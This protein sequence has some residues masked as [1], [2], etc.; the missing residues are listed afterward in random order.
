MGSTGTK[1]AVV[2]GASVE[3]FKLNYATN[4]NLDTIT[5]STSGVSATI[6]S[7]T[8]GDVEISFSGH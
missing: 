3:Y 5:N 8:G 6:L 4:S 1:V 2:A 7:P